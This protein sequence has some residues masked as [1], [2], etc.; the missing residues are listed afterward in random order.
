M[1]F[2]RFRGGPKAPAGTEYYVD[3]DGVTRL[4]I[5]GLG[6]L[7]PARGARFRPPPTPTEREALHQAVAAEELAALLRIIAGVS[8]AMKGAPNDRER[9]RLAAMLAGYQAQASA[10][11]RELGQQF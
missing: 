5:K 4:R 8:R 3:H 1:R 2:G 6:P 11:Q 7:G 10:L 9:Q